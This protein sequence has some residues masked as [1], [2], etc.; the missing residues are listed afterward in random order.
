MKSRGDYC[1][2]LIGRQPMIMVR[3]E[4]GDVNVLY[5]RCAH[6]GTMLCS[7][8][9][10]NTGNSFM[11]SY[12]GWRFHLNGRVK[13][14]PV[15]SGYDN[16]R[17]SL[18][19]P[20][21]HVKPAARVASYRGFVFAC[22]SE[23]GPDLKSWLGGA[24]AAFDDMCNRAPEGEVE[25]VPNCFRMIQKSNRKIFLENQLDGSHPAAKS[26]GKRSSASTS[27]TCWSIRRSRCNR[28]CS[29]FARCARW[30]PTGR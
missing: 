11:C 4:D 12:H 3:D 19:S 23:D 29:S 13:T 1:T 30:R 9:A 22:L 5:N 10:G 2:T 6:R 27:T 25:I 21:T 7:D 8:R 24:A 20:D 16:T 28:R 15:M 14:I 26:A 18:D 17:F